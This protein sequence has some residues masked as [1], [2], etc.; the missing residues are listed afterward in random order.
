MHYIIFLVLISLLSTACSADRLDAQSADAG[1]AVSSLNSEAEEGHVQHV[2]ALDAQGV[3][4]D[5]PDIVVLD[6]RTAKEYK[7]GHIAGGKNIDFYAA[8]FENR[9]SAL[10]K[11]AP[12]LLHCKSGG[13]SSKALKLME[14]LGFKN[15]YHLEGGF[16]AWK[17]AGLAVTR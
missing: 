11:A 10:D 1:A 8:D 16:D 3:I 13:R 15:I 2:T 17:A 14:R 9:L 5:E 4:A 6:V 12:Y 7:A